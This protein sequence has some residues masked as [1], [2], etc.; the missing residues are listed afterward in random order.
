MRHCPW[1]LYKRRIDDP[2]QVLPALDGRGD[3]EP[4]DGK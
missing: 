4:G 2:S 1:D 3:E